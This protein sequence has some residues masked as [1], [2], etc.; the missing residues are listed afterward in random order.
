MILGVWFMVVPIVKMQPVAG[1][2]VVGMVGLG[3]NAHAGIWSYCGLIYIINIL[4]A[5]LNLLP[6]MP[7]DGGHIAITFIRRIFGDGRLALVLTKIVTYLG[8]FI[9]IVLLINMLM[10]D[11]SAGF[12]FFTGK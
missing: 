9:L 7:F 6:L 2:G 8:F 3:A 10:S 4:L 11:F 1:G 12:K 5:A